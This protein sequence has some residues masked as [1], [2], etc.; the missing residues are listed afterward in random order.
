MH[1]DGES[2]IRTNERLII[3]KEAA[4]V[5]RARKL[6]AD[7]KKARPVIEE[8]SCPISNDTVKRRAKELS[9]HIYNLGGG[10]AAKTAA[11]VERLCQQPEIKHLISSHREEISIQEE[12]IINPCNKQIRIELTFIVLKRQIPWHWLSWNPSKLPWSH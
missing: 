1:Q 2:P 7:V 10:D 3:A 6:Q 9:N 4:R 12:G 11:I 5:A 8:G